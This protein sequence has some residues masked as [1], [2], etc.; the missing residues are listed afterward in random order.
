MEEKT[1]QKVSQIIKSIKS[2]LEGEFRHIC[3][4]GEITS[5]Y[6]AASGHWYFTLSDENSSINAALFRGEAFNNPIIKKLVNGDKI[7]CYG[8]LGVYSKK[9]TFQ[10]I[11]NKIL[12]S[13]KG[14]L[15]AR[16]EQ[17]KKKL[18][19]E[20]LFDMANKKKIPLFPRRIGIVTSLQ[21]A[22]LQD[23]INIYQ[24]RACWVDL[25]VS[26]AL[27]QGEGA[28]PSLQTALGNLISYSLKSEESQKI[29]VIVLTRGG[30]SLEDL[31]PFNDEGLAWDIFNSPIPI[32]SAVGHQVNFS[33]SDQVADLSCETPSAAAEVL[34]QEQ[35][36]LQKRIQ[37]VR[38]RL[39]Q[40]GKTAFNHYFRILERSGPHIYLDILWNQWRHHQKRLERN[41]PLSRTMELMQ[42]HEKKFNLDDL[43]GK[44]QH[45][46][47]SL[48]QGITHTFKKNS[49]MLFSLNPQK[50]LSR[51]YT[52]VI[53]EKN[54][55]IDGHKK[56]S[57]LENGIKI[58]I[59]FHDGV[60]NTRKEAL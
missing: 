10:I 14:D 57:K 18:A 23:F 16:L 12:S 28:P 7:V 48:H 54:N 17:I 27:V 50:V 31:W 13:G 37:L 56:F 49:E 30:G 34:T 41:N 38:D 19:K 45:N 9:G 32:V 51:G 39:A 29:D 35:Y 20:G 52:Y 21:G 36:R 46:F 40:Y 55:I 60:G 5:V 8:S 33:I 11:A 24:R 6:Q 3:V 26:P 1:P 42:I 25:L 59:T 58:K 2:L 43:G 47:K 22:A 4:E 44:L 15:Q 53:D